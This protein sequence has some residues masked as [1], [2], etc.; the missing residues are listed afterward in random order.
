VPNLPEEILAKHYVAGP[1]RERHEDIH[2][3]RVELRTSGRTV[4]FAGDRVDREP[5]KPKHAAESRVCCGRLR[6]VHTQTPERSIS[7]EY[8][9]SIMPTKAEGPSL[10]LSRQ[11]SETVDL[12]QPLRTAS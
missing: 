2:D 3:L 9:R 7:G 4:H 1:S 11:A 10:Y 5:G 12:K 8:Q 6:V